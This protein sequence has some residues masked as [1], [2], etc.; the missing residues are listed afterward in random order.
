MDFYN[1]LMYI[2]T[3]NLPPGESTSSLDQMPDF[4]TYLQG[5]NSRTGNQTFVVLFSNYIELK[6]CG[7][8]A[9]FAKHDVG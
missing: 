7:N 9:W 8:F 6:A 4:N 5:T 2:D 1:F 3:T